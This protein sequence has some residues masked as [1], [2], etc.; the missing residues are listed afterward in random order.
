MSAQKMSWWRR[1]LSSAGRERGMVE[2]GIAAAGGLLVVGAVVGNGVAAAAM[3]M[4]D[5]QTWLGSDDGSV[6]QINPATGQPEYRIVIG[7]DGERMEVTQDDGLLVV[8]NL[9]TGVVTSIDLAGLVA[10]QGRQTDGETTVLIGGGVVMLAEMEP[11]FVQVVDP[12]SMQSVGAPYRAGADLSDVVIDDEGTVWMMTTSGELRELDWIAESGEFSVSLERPVAGAGPGTRLVPHVSGVTVFAPDGGAVLQ[13]GV[14][15]DYVQ[16]VPALQGEVQAA[17]TSPADLSPASAT[18]ESL[19]FMISGRQLL[20]VD[21]ASIECESPLRPAVFERRVY[22]PCGGAGRVVVLDEAGLSAGPDIVVPGGGDPALIVDDGRLVVHDPDDG[23]IVVVQQDGST[24]V[25]D[26]NGAEVPIAEAEETEPLPP[27]TTGTTTPPEGGSTTPPVHIEPQSTTSPT[28]EP[29]SGGDD[30]TD[31]STGDPADGS[32]DA[33]TNG[34]GGDGPTTGGGSD[35]D[36]DLA[37]TGVSA[38]VEPDDSVVV[39]WTP[40]VTEP[41]AYLI[42]SSDGAV[43]QTVAADRTSA[44]LTTLTCGTTV[45]LTVYAQ[46]GEQMVGAATDVDTSACVDPPAPSQLTPDGVV[47]ERAGEDIV[48]GWTAPEIAPERYVVTGMGESVTVD[49]A[50]TS[51]VI[52][53]V[54]C[55]DP[56]EFEVTA[57]HPDAGEYSAGSASTTETCAVDPADQRP[58]DVTLTRISGND[59]RLTWTAPVI[60]PTGFTV[61]GNGVDETL[62][63]GA[64]SLDVAIPCVA[65]VRLTVT[66]NHADGTASPVQSNQLSNT[67][68]TTTTPPTLTAPTGVT[69]THLGGDQVEVEWSG[70]SPAAAEYVVFPS[71]GGSVSAGTATSATLTVARGATYTFTVEARWQGQTAT[72]AASNSVTVPAP[73]TAPGAPTNVQASTNQSPPFVTNTVTWTAPSD[74]GSPLTGYTLVWDG[75]TIDL[76]PGQTSWS[77]QVSCD[78][79]SEVIEA[80]DFEVRLSASNAIG[81]GPAA[82]A[83]VTA[84]GTPAPPTPKDGDGVLD[85]VE[86]RSDA[87]QGQFHGSIS[88]VPIPSWASSGGSC[89]ASVNGGPPEAFSCGQSAVLW[90]GT[91]QRHIGLDGWVSVTITW[92][93]GSATS[94]TGVTMPGEAWCEYISGEGERCYQVASL[95]PDDPDVEIDPLPWTPPEPPNPPVLI[96]GVGLLFGAGTMRTLRALRRRGL[97]ETPAEAMATTETTRDKDAHR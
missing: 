4:S 62:G 18:D 71:S 29:P 24:T 38:A 97:L 50:E 74:G 51:V 64:T 67:C 79:C 40:A 95:D 77:E 20:T 83:S 55:G 91:A 27:V 44:T 25:T 84:G 89:T 65:T 16:Q 43:T 94:S 8:T 82:V 47:A 88:Y 57:V 39:T 85:A 15:A 52:P 7:G 6:V 17:S 37:P 61:T 11:G 92:P 14:G 3:D 42:V 19:V 81:A 53:G 10:G 58:R 12:V 87:E 59:Y 72:S 56:I 86:D 63:A 26:L 70:S 5:G 41:D 80:P 78:P 96:A 54:A 1:R 22:V 23:R 60:A 76:G 75:R 45:R 90:S 28:G 69:A 2:V 36:P 66:A 32:T 30:A 35:V 9:E 73:A 33:P 49:G 48:V 34:G 68:T 21:M 31:Q 93:G 46:H 13:I